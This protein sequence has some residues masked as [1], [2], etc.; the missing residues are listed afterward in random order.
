[1][2]IQ[3]QEFYEGAALHQLIRGSSGTNS[4]AHSPPYFI[5]NGSLQVHLKYSTAKRSPWGFTFLPDEQ[6]LLHQRAQELRMV[7]GLICGPDGVATVHYEDYIRIAGTKEVA[8]RI[9]CKR[10]HR[11]HFEI[12]GPDGALPGKVAPS[13]WMRLL[14]NRR[15]QA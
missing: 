14:D 10:N 12:V 5:F 7:L 2:G 6:T 15:R 4:I 9:S 1:M 8:L 11:E 3:K 13:D